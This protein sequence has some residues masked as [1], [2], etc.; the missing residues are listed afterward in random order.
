MR[1]PST[2]RKSR[3][4]SKS[5]VR[6]Y[7]GIGDAE[8]QTPW[9][10]CRNPGICL[11]CAQGQESLK[12]LPRATHCTDRAQTFGN[13]SPTVE[14]CPPHPTFRTK[15][16]A[17]R[18]MPEGKSIYHNYTYTY[19][20]APSQGTSWRGEDSLGRRSTTRSDGEIA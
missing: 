2:S 6:I 19:Y 20:V 5:Y 9:G 15:V 7:M 16:R 4:A 14:L 13:V 11:K 12:G 10:C 3:F 1:V 17:Q 8:T 18:D